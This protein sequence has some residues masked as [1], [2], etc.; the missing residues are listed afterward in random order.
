MAKVEQPPSVRRVVLVILDG[1]GCREDAPDNAT[2]R[3]A[4]PRWRELVATC[5]HTTLD[6]SEQ[7]VGLPEGQVG[8]SEVGHLNIGAGRIVQ[9]DITRI[10]QA[11]ANGTLFRSDLLLQ[12]M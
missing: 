9:M 7:R 3:A 8:N 10:D 5:P 11:I 6:A 12:A 4:T 2:T 1:V